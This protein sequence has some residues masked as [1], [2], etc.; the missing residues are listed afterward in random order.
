MPLAQKNQLRA[1]FLAEAKKQTPEAQKKA[2][3]G[4]AQNLEAFFSSRAFGIWA[5]YRAIEN[6]A[7]LELAFPG[8]LKKGISLCFPRVVEADAGVMDFF[9][10][11]DLNQDF[12]RHPWGMLEPKADCQIVASEKIVGVFIPL[13]AFDIQGT[14][15]GKGRA[16]Y[17]RY[18][19]L[20]TGKKIGIAFEWQFSG[21]EIPRE[22]HDIALDAVITERKIHRF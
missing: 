16:F 14:R 1:H 18:L 4:I 19:A 20:F 6:E 9:M 8:L 7:S 21:K 13:L 3:A 2:N 22:A 17:D 12:E 15:L 10:A 11:K 5:A